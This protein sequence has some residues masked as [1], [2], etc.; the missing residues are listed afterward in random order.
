MSWSHLLLKLVIE[1][2]IP[3]SKQISITFIFNAL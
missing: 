3:E 2:R 1:F